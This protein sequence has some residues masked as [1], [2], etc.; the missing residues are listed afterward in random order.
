MSVGLTCESGVT[1][2]AS[3]CETFPSALNKGLHALQPYYN[4]QND[5]QMGKTNNTLTD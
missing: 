4:R 5:V 2:S 3:G 1:G